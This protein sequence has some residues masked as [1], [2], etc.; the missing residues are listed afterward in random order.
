MKVTRVIR[1]Y[2]RQVAV[3]MCLPLTLTIITG[4]AYPIFDGWFSLHKASGFIL[5]I[6]S[7]SIFGLEAIYPVLNGL[8]LMG[9][10]ITGLSMTNLFSKKRSLAEVPVEQMEVEKEADKELV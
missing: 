1:R 10:L 4:T 5:K 8:G 9:L 2:H 7:G 6:H 3:T